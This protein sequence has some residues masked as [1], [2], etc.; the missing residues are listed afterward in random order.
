MFAHRQHRFCQHGRQRVC[1]NFVSIFLRTAHLRG[2]RIDVRHR[3][4]ASLDVAA[5]DIAMLARAA[6]SQALWL[7]PLD[8]HDDRHRYVLRGTSQGY[9]Y[10]D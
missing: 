10:D 9:A 2:A 5:P 4:R 1:V 8:A 7:M 3:W 6:P